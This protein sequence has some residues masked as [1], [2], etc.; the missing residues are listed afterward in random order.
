MGF[1]SASG[2]DSN[3]VADI[4]AGSVQVQEKLKLKKNQNQNF[5]YHFDNLVHDGGYK[6]IYRYTKEKLIW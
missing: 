1:A 3:T 4:F 2:K 5:N 6:K